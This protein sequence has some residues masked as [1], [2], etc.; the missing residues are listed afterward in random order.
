MI[1][2]DKIV[3][4]E[5]WC[6]NCVY[7]DLDEEQDPCNDCLGTPINADSHKPVNF[8]KYSRVKEGAK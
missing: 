5:K 2:D 7:F 3:E 6:P 8:R 4:Y 1:G